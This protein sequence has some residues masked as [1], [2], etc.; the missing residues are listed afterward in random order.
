MK[1]SKVSRNVRF[2]PSKIDN[3]EISYRHAEKLEESKDMPSF[4]QKGD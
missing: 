1:D 4:C 2:S 3:H